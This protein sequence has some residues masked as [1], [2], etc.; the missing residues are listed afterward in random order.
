M[1]GGILTPAGVD[2]YAAYKPR[3]VEEGQR[4]LSVLCQAVDGLGI[5]GLVFVDEDGH[6][7]LGGRPIRGIADLPEIGRERLDP[8]G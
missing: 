5:L 3:E 7:D 4:P 1:G 2:P 6:G 8:N